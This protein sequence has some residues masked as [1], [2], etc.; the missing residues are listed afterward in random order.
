[1]E[2]ARNELVTCVIDHAERALKRAGIAPLEASSIA[3]GLADELVDVFGG[4]NITFPKE[5]SR[6][7]AQKEATIYAQFKAGASYRDLAVTFDMIERGLR[8]L[9]KRVRARMVQAA[10]A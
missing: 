2:T 6:K 4:Q 1:M 5:F 10:K 8:K 3:T 9:L 7:Q